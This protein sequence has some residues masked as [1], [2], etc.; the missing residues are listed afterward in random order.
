VSKSAPGGQVAHERGG[1][2]RVELAEDVVEQQHGRGARE[3][4]HHD[5]AGEAERQG[6]GPLLSLR[7]LIARVETVDH[8][9]QL[10]AV[11]TDQREPTIDL[12]RGGGARATRAA[13]PRSC[14]RRPPSTVRAMLR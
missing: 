7:R 6:E 14:R 1:T 8:Q 5:M 11:R 3:L 10:V 4:A 13:D 9:M 2:L 12:R